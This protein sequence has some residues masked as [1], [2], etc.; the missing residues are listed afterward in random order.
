[1]EIDWMEQARRAKNHYIQFN[2]FYK[3]ESVYNYLI[4]KGFSHEIAYELTKKMKDKLNPYAYSP[5]EKIQGNSKKNAYGGVDI[6]EPIV[7]FP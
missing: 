4:E 6:N 7:I 1:M 2:M 5:L 3:K